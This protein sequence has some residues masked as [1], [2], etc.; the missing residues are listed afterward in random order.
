MTFDALTKF[1]GFSALDATSYMYDNYVHLT[2][3]MAKM[4]P[5]LDVH[6]HEINP[7]LTGSIDPGLIDYIVKERLFNFFL[8]N[9]CIPFTKEHDLMEKMV[10]NNP[11]PKPIVVYG[12]DDSYGIEG[13]L[14]RLRRIVLR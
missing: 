1:K 4:N 11:W 7:P 9:G 13:D 5:G 10:Q 6:H 12:Y 2:T 3:T 14:L 8:Y